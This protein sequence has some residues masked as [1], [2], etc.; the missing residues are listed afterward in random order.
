MSNGKDTEDDDGSGREPATKVLLAKEP[1]S[2]SSINQ[3]TN[4]PHRSDLAN[5]SDGHRHQ[6]EDV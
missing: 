5:W 2:D 3:S 6:D 4:F 1:T